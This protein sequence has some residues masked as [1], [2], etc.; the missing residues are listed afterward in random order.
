[1]D[2]ML[3]GMHTEVF[4]V[5]VHSEGYATVPVLQMEPGVILVVFVVEVHLITIDGKKLA[6]LFI[7]DFDNIVV[8]MFDNPDAS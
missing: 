3:E 4:V 5:I 8:Q 2:R 1:M 6:R 7:L